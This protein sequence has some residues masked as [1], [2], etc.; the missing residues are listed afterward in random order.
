MNAIPSIPFHVPEELPD[1]PIPV[2]ARHVAKLIRLAGGTLSIKAVL[3]AAL[4]SALAVLD[5]PTTRERTKPLRRNRQ[6]NRGSIRH[7]LHASQG[8]KCAECPAELEVK[9][10]HVR[11][12]LWRVES[13]RQVLLCNQCKAA[14]RLPKLSDIE[15]VNAMLATEGGGR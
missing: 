2:S 10:D 13:R 1:T 3:D 8:G 7:E 9:G 15:D 6:R 12:A 4:D 14:K 5:K 11:G